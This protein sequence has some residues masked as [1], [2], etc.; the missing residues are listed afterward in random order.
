H[1]ELNRVGCYFRDPEDSSLPN[2]LAEIRREFDSHSNLRM[3]ILSGLLKMF[4]L[5]MKR[6][7][8]I[9]YQD[10]QGDEIQLF[11]RFYSLVE[12]QF[13]RKKQVAEYAKELFVTP[14]HLNSVIKK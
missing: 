12:D 5:Y 6:S 13:R 11:N 3:D 9:C 2:A 7:A 8:T 1:G 4:L 10:G 14:G